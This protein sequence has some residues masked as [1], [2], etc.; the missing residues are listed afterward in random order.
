MYT[1]KK[2]WEQ[3]IADLKYTLKTKVVRNINYIRDQTKVF[4]EKK[5]VFEELCF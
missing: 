1:E 4:E 3:S 2:N 5:N